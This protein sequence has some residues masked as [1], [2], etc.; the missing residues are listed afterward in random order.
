MESGEST[1]VPSSSSASAPIGT[2]AS[3]TVR[4][5]KAEAARAKGNACVK[6]NKFE[7]AVEHYSEALA[8]D[9]SNH[10]FFCHRSEGN[11]SAVPFMTAHARFPGK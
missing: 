1:L 5:F 6:E 11:L 3:R 9:S 10:E 7:E 2:S 4:I 8:M